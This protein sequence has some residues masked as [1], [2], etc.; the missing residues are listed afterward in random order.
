[1][2]DALAPFGQRGEDAG[3]ARMAD[4]KPPQQGDGGKA[5]GNRHADSEREDP[6]PNHRRL[7]RA[8]HI[9]QLPQRPSDQSRGS[10]AAC[11]HG[12]EIEGEQSRLETA[13]VLPGDEIHG[14]G[15]QA[16][17]QHEDAGEAHAAQDRASQQG[18]RPGHAQEEQRQA[19]D[20]EHVPRRQQTA[21]VVAVGQRGPQQHAQELPEGHGDQQRTYRLR[22]VEDVS[23][24]VEQHALESG[25]RKAGDQSQQAHAK[26]EPIA[27]WHGD[28][29]AFAVPFR[30]AVRVVS[31]LPAGCQ[32]R[33][34][35]G[36]REEQPGCATG[37]C[38]HFH[39]ARR[40][41][42]LDDRREQRGD[43][44]RGHRAEEQ[45]VTRNPA[46]CAAVH[47]DA[48]HQGVV[49]HV[50][51]RIGSAKQQKRARHHPEALRPQC[52]QRVKQREAGPARH[53]A[54]HDQPAIAPARPAQADDQQG[55]QEVEN[56]VPRQRHQHE[57]PGHRPGQSE[58]IRQEIE[59]GKIG[60]CEN[61]VLA[62]V[63]A[64]IT[65]QPRFTGNMPMAG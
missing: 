54:R 40:D 47:G 19:S 61:E 42:L 15:Q 32:C 43:R 65:Q 35:H 48:R 21:L 10:R 9:A 30:L 55:G 27:H 24:H 62:E 17:G 52:R 45:A 2:P 58:E 28:A 44:Q 12:H 25:D 16:P 20:A 37:Q 51:H 3:V 63:S 6:A 57:Q 36:H 5:S 46:P 29:V 14:V 8:G 50:D 4:A 38:Q 34:G 60:P 41:G 26:D 18:G 33:K 22:P 59:N 39:R 11:F 7:R 31:I 13:L 53:R 64:G 56:Q 1:M 23:A 49:R